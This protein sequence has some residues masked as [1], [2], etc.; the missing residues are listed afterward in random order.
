MH[1][2]LVRHGETLLKNHAEF[3]R[4]EI[5][6]TK[7]AH[8]TEEGEAQIELTAEILDETIKARFMQ[9]G[10]DWPPIPGAI[11]IICGPS[12]RAHQSADII[13]NN[14]EHTSTPTQSYDF[15]QDLGQG[16][17]G[18]IPMNRL[19][20]EAAA[21]K[22]AYDAARKNLNH[23]GDHYTTLRFPHHLTPEEFEGVIEDPLL[24][25]VHDA[26]A[27]GVKTV[28]MVGS[29]INQLLVTKA[30]CA[31]EEEWFNE[32][33]LNENRAPRGSIR[34]IIW[35]GEDPAIDRG[36]IHPKK[37]KGKGPLDHVAKR[38]PPDDD[39]LA[40]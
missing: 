7:R 27:R 1:I 23:P 22:E 9:D 15:L 24:E 21:L 3:V 35:H 17:A 40:R 13:A 36:I 33:V 18:E 31:K 4:T 32:A 34:H 8:L 12:T 5:G 16:P 11:E 30:L 26:Q 29:A 14:L 19:E 37:N 39:Q 2:L 10:Y 28:I 6:D 25:Y 38:M 20:Q